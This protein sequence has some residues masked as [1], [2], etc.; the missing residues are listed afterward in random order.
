MQAPT[1]DIPLITPEE[2]NDFF[3]EVRATYATELVYFDGRST[4]PYVE[5]YRSWT[6]CLVNRFRDKYLFIPSHIAFFFIT[7]ALD[8]LSPLPNSFTTGDITCKRLQYLYRNYRLQ[9]LTHIQPFF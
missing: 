3:N 7:L 2:F 9:P 8:N 4:S 5:D 6:F 1:M